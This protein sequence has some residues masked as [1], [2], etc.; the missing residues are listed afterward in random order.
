MIEAIRKILQE[1]VVRLE[2]DTTVE[3]VAQKIVQAISQPAE[4]VVDKQAQPLDDQDRYAVAVRRLRDE[5]ARPGARYR[6]THILEEFLK[7]VS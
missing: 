6:S 5:W 4:Q 3:D 2:C 7:E 1:H